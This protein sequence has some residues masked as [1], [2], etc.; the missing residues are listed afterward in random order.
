M[1]G[2]SP[3]GRNLRVSRWSRGG[4]RRR[5]RTP[6]AR[7][8][9]AAPGSPQRGAALRAVPLGRRPAL[10]DPVARGAIEQ[11]PLEPLTGATGAGERDPPRRRPPP[12]QH[13]AGPGPPE[14]APEPARG[15][16]ARRGLSIRRESV[17]SLVG[18]RIGHP[19]DPLAAYGRP[20]GALDRDA[21][22]AEADHAR[23][24]VAR[25]IAEAH[26][27]RVGAENRAGGGAT[28][29]IEVPR[30]AD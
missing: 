6:G 25:A 4:A 2:P 20:V 18:T 5:R 22:H 24:A 8:G 29:W 13:T 10:R 15:P 26:G 19:G 16:S 23:L 21:G 7:H 3:A 14:P 28:F 12:I 27:G 11:R 17:R 30:A 9:L 1:S